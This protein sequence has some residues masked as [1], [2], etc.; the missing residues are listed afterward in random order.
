MIQGKN[1]L[2]LLLSIFLS[3]LI[4]AMYVGP[5]FAAT[6]Q[7]TL[8]ASA[9]LAYNLKGL[10][11]NVAVQKAYIASTYVY[12]TQRSGGTCYLS[13]LLIN[14]SDA[15]YVDEMTVTNAGHCQTLDMYTY[16]GINYFYF[17]SKADSS[18]SN[19]WSLQV[20]RLQ[21]A[22]GTTYDYTD[23]HRFSYMNYA[24]TTGTSLGETYRVDAGGNSTHTVF[25]VQ[26][27]EGTVTW[28]IY[29]T[30][31]LNQLLDNNE[32]VQMDSA[33]AVS[34]CVSSFTQ[35]GTAIVRPND[36][37]QG[38]DM[39]DNTEIYTSGGAEGETPQIAMMSNTGTYKTLVKITN[40][41]T[42]EIEGVQTK[43]NNVYFIIVAD[44]VN[45][46]NTQ[47]LYY[48]PDSIF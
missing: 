8:N 21:Y 45:K 43:N 37:F 47:K 15:T 39:L 44:P 14:G 4:S 46:T 36:S 33:A 17:S 40:V 1:R 25:R 10:N 42:H 11:H 27:K 19:Y 6:P 29:D 16:N 24:N 32:L 23:L 12:V 38:A 7:N 31:A 30:V 28:S 13:R 22:A 35:S 34:A 5:V 2:K 3:F 9:A 48:V 41:G 26:T 20:A 18:T